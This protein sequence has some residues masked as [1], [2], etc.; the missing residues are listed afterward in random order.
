MF[1]LI[2]VRSYSE[3]LLHSSSELHAPDNLFCCVIMIKTFLGGDSF[4]EGTT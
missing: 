4:V 2:P 3:F 1:V